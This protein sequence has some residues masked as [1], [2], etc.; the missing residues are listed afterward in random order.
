VYEA[1]KKCS[2]TT[3]VS[4]HIVNIIISLYQ[5]ITFTASDVT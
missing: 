5:L 2:L 1:I 3:T 4:I